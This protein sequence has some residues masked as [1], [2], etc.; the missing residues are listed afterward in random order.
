MLRLPG[1]RDDLQGFHV[2]DYFQGE[3]EEKDAKSKA[4]GGAGRIRWFGRALVHVA[5][6][7]KRHFVSLQQA[8][9]GKHDD[10]S[11]TAEELEAVQT[12]LGAA[13]AKAAFL[14]AKVKDLEKVWRTPTGSS[15]RA[16]RSSA[17]R[18]RRRRRRSCGRPH[19][20]AE[21]RLRRAHQGGA[22]AAGGGGAGQGRGAGCGGEGEAA[23]ADRGGS[24]AGA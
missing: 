19:Q 14:E 20:A 5:A 1:H 16:T 15:R 21:V 17:P 18:R 10:R 9:A 12:E 13:L 22:C 8:M 2:R 7:V 24:Q 11:S 6:L 4:K 23:R 3:L